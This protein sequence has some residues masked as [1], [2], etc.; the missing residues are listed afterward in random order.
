MLLSISRVGASTI[1]AVR[2]DPTIVA[3]LL[4][5]PAAPTPQKS[6]M[7]G[8]LFGRTPPAAPVRRVPPIGDE[9]RLDLEQHW[10]ILHYLFT[11]SAWNGDAPAAFLV[12]GGTPVGRD[13]GYGPP[14]LFDAA[15]VVE[16]A[17]YLRTLA[18]ESL[19]ARYDPAAIAASEIYWTASTT[20][21]EA[22]EELAALWQ[23]VLALRAFLDE[24][25]QRGDG[26]LVEIY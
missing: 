22:A 3:D 5:P 20:P 15:A 13:L 19:S 21:D 6:G 8:R 23:S 14:R 10:H 4:D 7:F 26:V 1:A 2:A 24:S 16:I 17:T 18:P 9:D 25:A 12:A 11:G